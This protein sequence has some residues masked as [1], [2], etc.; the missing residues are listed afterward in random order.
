M[1]YLKPPFGSPEQ[2]L[3]Y[4]ARYPHKVAISN[5]RILTIQDHKVTFSYRDNMR[6]RQVMT[7][8][9]VEFLRRF[10][11][12]VL[13]QGFVRIRY[14]QGTEMLRFSL[15]Q[16]D[17]RR[18]LTPL[19]RARRCLGRAAGARRPPRSRRRAEPAPIQIP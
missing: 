13:P 14:S 15:V 3:K 6:G 1:V 11:L 8:D 16:I 17:D 4:M 2:V 9:G 18:S 10:L 5:R 19:L 12:H 7:L